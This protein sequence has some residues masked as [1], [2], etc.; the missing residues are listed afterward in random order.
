MRTFTKD[1]ILEAVKV[2]QNMSECAAWNDELEAI[3][4]LIMNSS[5]EDVAAVVQDIHEGVD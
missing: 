1:S 4:G 2:L 3:I 5:D